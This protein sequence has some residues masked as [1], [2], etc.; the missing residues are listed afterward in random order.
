MEPIKTSTVSTLLLLRCSY[1]S[2]ARTP[3]KAQGLPGCRGQTA[4]VAE[5]TQHSST[6][7]N[8]TC[9]HLRQAQAPQTNTEQTEQTCASRAVQSC[10]SRDHIH[11]QDPHMIQVQDERNATT[12]STPFCPTEPGTA[13]FM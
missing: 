12:H 3:D 5:S 6:Q 11:H 2:P 9:C 4:R 7:H 13:A 1:D 8:K 10:V